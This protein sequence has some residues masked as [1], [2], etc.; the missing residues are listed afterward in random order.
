MTQGMERFLGFARCCQASCPPAGD[1]RE[2]RCIICLQFPSL[3]PGISFPFALPLLLVKPDSWPSGLPQLL[4][5]LQ[6]TAAQA[7]VTR[8]PAGGERRESSWGSLPRSSLQD[9]LPA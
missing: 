8:D 1:G 9:F 7:G 5:M 3:S 6:A 2:A 4:Q